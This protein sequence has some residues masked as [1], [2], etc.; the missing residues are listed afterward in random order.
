MTR[1]QTSSK[2]Y[3]LAALVVVGTYPT[4][5]STE[6]I[7]LPRDS[8]G[9][10]L[11]IE[12][13]GSSTCHASPEPW[14][15]ATVLMKERLI[16]EHFDPHSKSFDSLLSSRAKSISKNLNLKN[17][18]EAP[19]CLTC[20]TT[21]VPVEQRGANFDV[22]S[23]VTCESCHGP[24]G[25]FLS[26][27]VQPDSNHQRNVATGLYP[28]DSPEHRTK[29]CLSCH[30]ADSDNEFMHKYY[31]AGHPRLRFEVETYTA[32]QPYHF[33][34]DADYKRRKSPVTPVFSWAKGQL[35]SSLT[36]I[37][38]LSR[39]IK[40]GSRLPELALFECSD[41][42]QSIADPSQI[43]RSNKNFGTPSVNV[44]NLIMTHAI[45]LTIEPVIAKKIKSDISK[46]LIDTH[47]RSTVVGALSRLQKQLRILDESLSKI[48][49]DQ[50]GGLAL[51]K[52][53]VASVKQFSPISYYV[54]EMSAMSLSSLIV[55]DYEAGT[56]SAQTLGNLEQMLDKIF[57]SAGSAS[58][59]VSSRY[60]KEVSDFVSRMNNEQ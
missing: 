3:V 42:H 21:Y 34:R 29:L 19:K 25:A 52:N 30:Q 20:H 6:E 1:W 31:A 24:G 12:T 54:A 47:S 49:T 17:A 11:G 5:S 56:I 44:S 15:N 23:G 16:W 51:A 39:N 53:V 40:S 18:F 55:S 33:N 32:N 57:E 48:E 22:Q 7:K 58:S 9:Q 46:L 10:F 41:C 14:R 45:A 36:V 28:T 26:T 59:F 60:L 13:C 50:V 43:S 37:D 8:K 4:L 2:P 27:H 35:I 38:S